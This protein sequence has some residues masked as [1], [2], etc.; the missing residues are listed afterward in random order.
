M[1]WTLNQ[2]PD[3]ALLV[4]KITIKHQYVIVAN[5]NANE[6]PKLE[7]F[8][9]DIDIF[10]PDT[11]HS[12]IYRHHVTAGETVTGSSRVLKNT[13]YVNDQLVTMLLSKVSNLG[14]LRMEWN[15]A[16]NAISV[17]H[18]LKHA[19]CACMEGI[20]QHHG[21]HRLK[22]VSTNTRFDERSAGNRGH[23]SYVA[24]DIQSLVKLETVIATNTFPHHIMVLRMGSSILPNL[25]H[26]RLNH[27]R[28]ANIQ[29][30]SQI[31]L[32]SPNLQNLEYHHV[33]ELLG[34]AHTRYDEGIQNFEDLAAQD[35]PTISWG[36]FTA[37]LNPMTTT[38]TH[39]T[40][41]L[42]N[43]VWDQPNGEQTPDDEIWQRKGRLGSLRGLTALKRLEVPIFVLLGWDPQ[44]CLSL[45]ETLPSGLQE[46]CFRD[47][48]VDADARSEYLWMPWYHDT[49]IWAVND[50]AFETIEDITFGN[51]ITNHQLDHR[52]RRN[53]NTSL[54]IGQIEN[55]LSGSHKLHTLIIKTIQGRSWP[56]ESVQKLA[57]ICKR[58]N[59]VCKFHARLTNYGEEVRETIVEELDSSTHARGDLTQYKY[60]HRLIEENRGGFYERNVGVRGENELFTEVQ[61]LVGVGWFDN[62]PIGSNRSSGRVI[63]GDGSLPDDYEENGGWPIGYD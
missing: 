43:A 51:R 53:C 27:T 41:A 25:R 54:I 12:A 7:R 23:L 24:L 16:C 11:I 14:I 1:I 18:F 8:D 26:L 49:D 35:R 56:K 48:L 46:L 32:C 47:D 37:A 52:W 40:I 38:L 31:L 9:I 28:Q 62:F 36:E 55:Y 13:M 42:D 10:L 39:L 33:Q 6:D 44:S 60:N 29:D 19:N 17:Y 3:L 22:E 63:V 45:G 30:L 61:E 20:K 4:Q 2:R 5:F 59:V 57:T 21:F 15:F 58:A 50:Y 34:E